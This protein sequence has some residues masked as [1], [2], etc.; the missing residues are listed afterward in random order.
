LRVAGSDGTL[1]AGHFDFSFVTPKR[2]LL[3]LPPTAIVYHLLWGYGVKF[4]ND[5]LE[6]SR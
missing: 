4:L 5:L 6:I 1:L 3:I 2:G